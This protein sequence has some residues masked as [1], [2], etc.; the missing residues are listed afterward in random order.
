MPLFTL[1]KWQWNANQM[2]GRHAHKVVIQGFRR[3]LGK[4]LH[5][6]IGKLVPLFSAAN[7][8]SSLLTNIALIPLVSRPRAA[9]SAF[10]STT[11]SFDKSPDRSIL[12]YLLENRIKFRKQCG[13][14][15][16]VYLIYYA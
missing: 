12:V 11:L 6:V 8:A 7:A 1:D 3:T 4:F 10:S 13:D 9:N 16:G 5:V 15:I 2:A 14:I